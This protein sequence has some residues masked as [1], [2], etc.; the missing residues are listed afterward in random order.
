[1]TLE[2]YKLANLTRQP[3]PKRQAKLAQVIISEI[4]KHVGI[5]HRRSSDGG[6]G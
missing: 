5:D 3:C 6:T 1:M 2:F 4:T